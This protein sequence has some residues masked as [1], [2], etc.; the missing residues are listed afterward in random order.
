MMH[1]GSR[2]EGLGLRVEMAYTG[3]YFWTKPATG[4]SAS[5][6]TGSP[7]KAP[8]G[9]LWPASHYCLDNLVARFDGQPLW[10]KVAL[11]PEALHRHLS[12]SL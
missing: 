3:K 2:G 12:E 1:T 4:Y 9:K 6:A 5:W 11:H 10:G 7:Q 8:S